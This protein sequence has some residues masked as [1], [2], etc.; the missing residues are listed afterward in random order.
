MTLDGP[1]FTNSP[2][3]CLH[4]LLCEDVVVRNTRVFNPHWA[5]NGDAIDIDVML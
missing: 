2:A 4:L 3:W 5:Q 1:L